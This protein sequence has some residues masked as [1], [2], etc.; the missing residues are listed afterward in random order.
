MSQI[1]PN[2]RRS[3]WLNLVGTQTRHEGHGKNHKSETKDC[4]GSQ[5]NLDGKRAVGKSKEQTRTV[6]GKPAIERHRRKD[7]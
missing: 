3:R 4:F 6:Q 7:A 2:I 1:E 5:R